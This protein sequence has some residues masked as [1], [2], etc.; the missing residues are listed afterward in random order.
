[1]KKWYFWANLNTRWAY[2]PWKKNKQNQHKRICLVNEVS[3]CTKNL[4]NHPKIDVFEANDRFYDEIVLSV[5]IKMNRLKQR[6]K[7]WKRNSNN[8]NK[9]WNDCIPSVWK[10]TLTTNIQTHLQYT[11]EKSMCIRIYIYLCMA[12]ITASNPI[13]IRTKNERSAQ[14]KWRK[15]PHSSSD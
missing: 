2:F 14:K 8:N 13:Y 9:W 10:W 7:D 1:M 12:I 15:I 3:I 5:S 6:W 4:V 11:V